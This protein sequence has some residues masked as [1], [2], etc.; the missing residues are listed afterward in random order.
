[1]DTQP[2]GIEADSLAKWLKRG[3]FSLSLSPGFFG[4]Y[5]QVGALHAL[6]SVV[7]LVPGESIWSLSG[8]SAGAV[9]AAFLA[10]G[11]PIKDMEGAL[12][13]LRREHIW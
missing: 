1:M 6:D 4:F 11:M 13:E 7:P 5:A 2:S 9:T 3:P 12:L 8:A 10:S